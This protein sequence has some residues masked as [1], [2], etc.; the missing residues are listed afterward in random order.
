MSPAR[1]IG[2]VSLTSVFIRFYYYY[3]VPGNE[4]GWLRGLQMRVRLGFHVY[5]LRSYF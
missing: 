2:G 4:S 5:L 3:F 1:V